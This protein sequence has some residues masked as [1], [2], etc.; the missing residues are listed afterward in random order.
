MIFND[1][2]I[3][4]CGLVSESVSVPRWHF[5][6][7]CYPLKRHYLLYRMDSFLA[8]VAN[9]VRLGSLYALSMYFR[10]LSAE[11]LSLLKASTGNSSG[12][13]C[14]ASGPV[15]GGT[16]ARLNKALSL[17]MSTPLGKNSQLSWQLEILKH[18]KNG[19]TTHFLP[20][21]ARGPVERGKIKK[22]WKGLFVPLSIY[23]THQHWTVWIHLLANIPRNVQ[24]WKC[25]DLSNYE[26]YYTQ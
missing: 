7:G 9:L 10:P 22:S 24:V 1:R 23:Y 6:D 5:G 19:S 17:D 8:A 26:L 21:Q 13:L 16:F 11:G 25:G 4:I 15:P 12:E 3:W 14:A 20:R 2:D 18:G